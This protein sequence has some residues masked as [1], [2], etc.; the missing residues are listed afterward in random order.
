[1]PRSN[2]NKKK[3]SG[4]LKREVTLNQ[5]VSQKTKTGN[6]GGGARFT[7][8]RC[9]DVSVYLFQ[10]S[11]PTP[12]GSVCTYRSEWHRI[13]RKFCAQHIQAK[14]SHPSLKSHNATSLSTHR[15]PLRNSDSRKRM[16]SLAPAF[17]FFNRS[18]PSITKKQKESTLR[19][20]TNSHVNK[21]SDRHFKSESE[22]MIKVKL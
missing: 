1:M 10:N 16:P 11:D 2:K 21:Q 5:R 3:Q 9:P 18:S 8:L 20:S 12:S 22:Q 15:L 4:T 7:R 13:F 19:T 14:I 6:C 17:S